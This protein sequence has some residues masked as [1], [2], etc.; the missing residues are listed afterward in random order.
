MASPSQPKYRGI[1]DIDEAVRESS[2]VMEFWRLSRMNRSV[3]LFSGGLFDS[4]PAY[5]VDGLAIAN[6]EFD[7]IS[8][9]VR[10]ESSLR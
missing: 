6:A 7:C 3:P 10:G 1:I 5:V 9:V 8:E 2:R 4:W